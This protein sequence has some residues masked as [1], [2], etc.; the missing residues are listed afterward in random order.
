MKILKIFAMSIGT[1][2]VIGVIAVIIIGSI[3]PETYI[4]L[5]H[6]VPKKYLSEIRSIDLLESDDKIKYFYTDA[7]FDIKNGMYFVT[8]R[9]LV[10]F[11]ND[12]EEAGIIIFLDKI[13][14]V[15]VEY[16]ESFFNDSLVYVETTTGFEVCFP[17]S[18]DHGRDK[19]F[20]KYLKQKSGINKVNASTHL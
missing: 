19:D 16:D 7:M 18:S 13:V 6:Q 9:N 4:Y 3:C 1:I 11:C 8:D 5:G 12:W 10:L 2:I 14:R 20:V 15:D 17:L